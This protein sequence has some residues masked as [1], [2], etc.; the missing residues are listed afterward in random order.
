MKSLLFSLFSICITSPYL[1]AQDMEA[2][3]LSNPCLSPDGQTVIFS[4]EGDLWKAGVKDGQA[5]RL[6]AMQGYE[7]NPRISPD[8]KLIAFTGRQFGNPDIFVMPVNGGEIKQITWHSSNDEVSSWSWNSQYIY[9]TSNRFG[10]PA[11]F[12]VSV[13]GGTPK[14]VFGNYFFQFDHNLVEHPLS[15][16]IFFNDTWESNNQVQRKRYKGPFNPEIQSY[17]PATRKYRRYTDWEGKDF[18]TTIDKKGNIYFISDEANSEYNLYTMVNGIKTALT[19]FNSSI[20]TPMVNANGDKIVFEK[21]YQLWIYDVGTKKSGKLVI[22][23]FRNSILA[24][25]KD[26]EVRGNISAF[27]ISPDA[28]KIAFV[29]R[30]ELFVSDVEGKFIQLINR[31]SAERVKEIKWLNDNKTLLFGQTLGGYTNFYTILADGTTPVKQITADRRN[32]RSLVMNKKRTKAVY[33]S[34]RDELRLL[35]T[36]TWESKTIVKDE[37]WGFQ[38]SDPGFSPNADYVV[39]TAYRNFEQDIF[40]YNIKENK[41]VNLTKTGVSETSPF[42]SADGKYIYLTASRLK[43]LYPFG[44]Q[45]AKVYRLPLEKLDEPFRMDKYNELFKEEKKDTAKKDTAKKDDTTQVN[46][47]PIAIDTERILERLEQIGPSF[48]IQTL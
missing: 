12:K 14:R 17:N 32:N 19:T 15:G 26:Y 18:G 46:V 8:G 13:A 22:H 23:I 34:G 36:K 11:G 10:Q 3:F 44:F 37:I 7:T 41:T 35:D 25:E 1:S 45:N 9:F 24:K 43:P 21:D 27:D 40:V 47:A 48:G 5:V 4:Y 31:A 30:G 6:T 16:E 28:K 39:Y 38:G 29:S 2:Y 42:W 20:K 33:L